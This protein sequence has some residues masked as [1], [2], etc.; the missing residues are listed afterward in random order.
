MD[1]AVLEVGLGGRL[2]ATNICQ[3]LVSVITNIAL[4]HTAYL[5][6]TLT[7]I[8]REKAGIIKRN[9]VC[10]TAAT[11]KK[12]IDVFAGICHKKQARLLCLGVDFK[13]KIHRD[14][15]ISYEGQNRRIDRLTDAPAGDA[16][17]VQCRPGSGCC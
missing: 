7:A 17:V 6:K 15:S 12:V 2:D 11:Q 8:A 1:I 14:K 13:M 16:S 3:P 4:E 5:G 10:V 9:G